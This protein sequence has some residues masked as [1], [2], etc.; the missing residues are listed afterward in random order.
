MMKMT[1]WIS[2]CFNTLT[3]MNNQHERRDFLIWQPLAIFGNVLLYPLKSILIAIA[4]QWVHSPLSSG[5]IWEDI[6]ITQFIGSLN[7]ECLGALELQM[8]QVLNITTGN[9]YSLSLFL[10]YI[11]TYSIISLQIPISS[12][13]RTM[14][15]YNTTTISL[16]LRPH[17]M[18]SQT[19]RD[20]WSKP[21]KSI[22]SEGGLRIHRSLRS[23]SGSRIR[24][25][26]RMPS[27][28]QHSTG[29]STPIMFR[30]HHTP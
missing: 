5:V 25:G 23:G 8:R 16:T 29:K 4:P 3:T 26:R 19:T 18:M 22:S 12:S 24:K 6:Y 11:Y 21:R 27:E 9:R 1:G 14:A 17:L 13:L 10:V 30:I 2:E 15:I 20:A 28:T 7:A